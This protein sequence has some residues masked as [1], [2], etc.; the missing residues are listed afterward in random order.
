MSVKKQKLNSQ[1]YNKAK[2]I[3]KKQKQFTPHHRTASPRTSSPNL[4]SPLRVQSF[5]TNSRFTTSH[6]VPVQ[7]ASDD[8]KG[9]R[10]VPCKVKVMTRARVDAD[11]ERLRILVQ[12]LGWMVNHILG[13]PVG[14]DV[15]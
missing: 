3:E 15:V 13:R 5:V 4:L 1:T 2:S 14:N 7:E 11:L 10:S 6:P 8:F 12:F 9:P